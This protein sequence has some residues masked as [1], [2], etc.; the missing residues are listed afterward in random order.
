MSR[1]QSDFEAFERVMVETHQRQPI[2][3]QAGLCFVQPLALRCLAGGGR[4]S[5]GLFHAS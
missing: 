3:V 4:S 5:D 1:K 2:R